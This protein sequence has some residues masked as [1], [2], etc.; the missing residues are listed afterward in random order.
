MFVSICKVSHGG[1]IPDSS[2]IG[3]ND[4]SRTGLSGQPN[5]SQSLISFLNH[6]TSH[7]RHGCN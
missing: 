3:L 6:I 4:I 1:E 5:L 2:P 7:V